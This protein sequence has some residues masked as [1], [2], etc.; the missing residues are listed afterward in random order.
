MKKNPPQDTISELYPANLKN[1]QKVAARA[2]KREQKA[3][4]KS[5][6]HSRKAEFLH[7]AARA[8]RLAGMTKISRALK[9][10]AVS[11]DRKADA[12]EDEEQRYFDI[13]TAA[14]NKKR[15]LLRRTVGETFEP[16]TLNEILYPQ[17]K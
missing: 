16:K 3:G 9:R 13:Q 6:G 12:A 8:T 5:D 15:K 11:Q 2:E 10:G 7:G 1:V 4:D 14:D 17:D